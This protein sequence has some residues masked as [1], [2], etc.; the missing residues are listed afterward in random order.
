MCSTRCKKCLICKESIHQRLELDECLVCSVK[1]ASV[2]FQP[3]GHMCVCENCGKLMKKCIK[4]RVS[5]EKQVSFLQCCGAPIATSGIM[6][7]GCKD[8][9]ED[10]NVDKNDVKKLQQQL[11]EIKEQVILKF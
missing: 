11:H 9:N 1:K 10:E 7:N 4:C 5:I 2:L 8:V 3:C 6:N